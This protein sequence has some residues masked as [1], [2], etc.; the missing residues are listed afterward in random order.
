MRWLTTC[1]TQLS[2]NELSKFVKIYLETCRV[3]GKSPKTLDRYTRDLISFLE[4]ATIDG[5]VT[6]RHIDH[7]AARAK[8]GVGL[9]QVEFANV[10]PEGK[11]YIGTM[12]GCYLGCYHDKLIPGLNR[13]ARTIK[14][15]GARAALQIAHAGRQTSSIF[16]GTSTIQA[17][18]PI[19]LPGE[20]ATGHTFQIPEAMTLEDIEA[21]IENFANAAMRVKWAG[22]DAVAV[23]G[24][25][26]YLL[27]GFFSPLQNHREDNYGGSLENRMRLGIEVV[28]RIREKV[29]ADFP[30]GYKLS[31]DEYLAGGVTPE[32]SVVFGKELEKAGINWLECSAG[33]YES[34]HHA[35]PPMYWS[36]NPN[37]HLARR[38]KEVMSIPVMALGRQTDPEMMERI[39]I[40]GKAD[41]ISMG[42][43]LLCDPE[44][45]NKIKDGHLEDILRCTGC[46]ECL[47]HWWHERTITCSINPEVGRETEYA[48]R[49][50]I[51]PKRVLVIGSGPAGMEAA[52]VAALRGHDVTIFEKDNKLGG[53]LNAASVP[54]FK[55]PLRWFKS[56]Q[57]TQVKKAGVKIELKKE[58][59]VENVKS[60]APDEVI[61]ATGAKPIRPSIPGIDK[62]FVVFATDVLNGE[63]RVFN[64]VLV[65]GG[66]H[67]GC[68]TALFLAQQGNKNV[69]IAEM[70]E[71]VATDI[72][73][74]H[75]LA[76]VELL[77]ANDVN[78]RVNLMLHEV[79]DGEAV[80][81]DKNQREGSIKTEAIILA[82]GYNA[83]KSLAK[84]LEKQVE[85]L[86]S[87]GD[88]VEPQDTLGAIH[89]GAH[90]GRQ[91]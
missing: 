38:M 25:H 17:P 53:Q 44:L 9:L 23:H 84:A 43:P 16:T 34:S 32:D 77:Q 73:G 4:F 82:L 57:E 56:W 46:N 72:E 24:A 10:Q 88:C 75:K 91:V 30:I 2:E 26:G 27:F 14:E 58:A 89:A 40:E 54:D 71:S 81:L 64:N 47:N 11:G 13:I 5:E 76:L 15:N 29:G 12:L 66:G 79:R 20:A 21:S 67:V 83:D 70:K 42:R 35:H 45:P 41:M 39:L 65:V 68:E 78:V 19:P 48:I 22:F 37:V 28:K 61:V 6:Q 62:D 85:R 7:Y 86:Y 87:I 50:V 74:A 52:R 80:F 18:S 31:I 59:T 33:T 51:K 49:P 63:R 55:E 8:G 90:T 3:E 60:F 69:T 36:K 1:Y